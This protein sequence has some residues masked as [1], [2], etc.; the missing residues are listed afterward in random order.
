MVRSLNVLT[1]GRTVIGLGVG[2]AEGLELGYGVRTPPPVEY[3][4]EYLEAVGSVLGGVDY[5]GRHLTGRITGREIPSEVTPRRYGLLLGALGPRMVSVGGRT[6]DGVVTWLAPPGYLRDTVR[7][8]LD[9][10]ARSTG[11]TSP[12]LVALVPSLPGASRPDALKAAEHFLRW[13][14]ARPQYLRLLGRAGLPTTDLDSLYEGLLST[15]AVWGDTGQLVDRLAEYADAGVDEVAL[16]CYPSYT[17]G[18]AA[19]WLTL[20]AIEA[21][22]IWSQTIAIALPTAR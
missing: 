20:E 16:T 17:K 12:S 8:V 13:H 18:T 6:A 2:D 4:A 11:R 5:R 3:A 19:Q 9:D 1:T 21:A 10:A 15:T 14:L 7:P 22:L